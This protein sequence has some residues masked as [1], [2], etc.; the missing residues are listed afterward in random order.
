M[1]PQR[2]LWL[3]WWTVR[4]LSHAVEEVCHRFAIV[5]L[6]LKGPTVDRPR[7]LC[8]RGRGLAVCQIVTALKQGLDVGVGSGFVHAVSM[9]PLGVVWGDWWTLAQLARRPPS[10]LFPEGW[11]VIGTKHRNHDDCGGDNTQQPKVGYSVTSESVRFN[12][13]LEGKLE[14]TESHNTF[15]NSFCSSVYSS[16]QV[17]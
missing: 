1:A 12:H 16:P 13:Q 2:V 10:L 11:F 6:S 14:Q 8:L 5:C 7:I 15:T 17:S 3:K 9:A 4:K